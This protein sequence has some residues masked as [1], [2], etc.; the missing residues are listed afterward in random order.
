MR[1]M[2]GEYEV[3]LQDE[4]EY[5]RN[6]TDNSTHYAHEYCRDA[7]SG[8]ASAH[9]V[10]VFKQGSLLG[11]AVVLGMGGATGIHE[12]SLAYDGCTLYVASGDSV[13]ALGLPS[14]ELNWCEKVDFATCFGVF[15]LED[16]NC[17]ITWGELEIA[18]YTQTGK[19]L[20]R[21]QGSDIFSERFE[22][23]EDTA[24]AVDFN[25]DVYEINLDNGA[26]LKA[27]A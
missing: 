19:N 22:L 25:G 18:C 9:G 16:R 26:I 8:Y 21:A 12:H 23:D 17:L 6:S 13:Y 20:W 1:R 14:L 2:F 27:E 10:S 4:S 11:N 5:S 24:K 7:V 3:V 15:W